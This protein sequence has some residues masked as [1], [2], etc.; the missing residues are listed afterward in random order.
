[1]DS[2]KHRGFDALPNE[3]LYDI[4]HSFTTKNVLTFAPVSRRFHSIC[5]RILQNRLTAAATLLDH[6]LM[7]ELYP[8]SARL[9]AGKLFCTSLGTSGLDDKSIESLSDS[10]KIGHLGKAVY[11]RFRPQ[12]Q[13]VRRPS[14]KHP[15][16][17]IPGSRTH[18]T[19]ADPGIHVHNTESNLVS[20]QVSLDADELFTQLIA[21]L[22]LV[23]PGPR[24][25]TI[26]TAV[27]VCE[28]T[29]RVWR[30]W[31]ATQTKADAH[32]TS[33]SPPADD[34]SIL[35]VNTADQAGGVKF[36][37]KERKWKRDNP[38]L[39]SSEEEVA[40]SYT[41][42]LEEVVLRTSHLLFVVEESLREQHEPLSRQLYFRPV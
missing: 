12:H 25:D 18:P 13:E 7:L 23:K 32:L 1:M 14:L 15:A 39:F 24:P 42:D 2:T 11:S 37:V 6:I 28:G 17:D 4:L 16:G 41:V 36:R 9:T 34:S 27:E 10:A 5:V 20:Q 40:V 31:L 26:L 29:I 22:M 8:P 21:T 3:L 35:W 19:S 38:V 33:S 30:D